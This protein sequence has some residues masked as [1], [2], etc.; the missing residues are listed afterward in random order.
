MDIVRALIG[1]LRYRG[2]RGASGVEYGFIISLLLMGS[3]ASFEMM[4]TRLGE[5][6]QEASVDIGRVDLDHFDV[7]TTTSTTTQAPAGPTADVSFQEKTSEHGSGWKA[8][9]KLTFF[10]DDGDGLDDAD[11]QVTLTTAQ[12]ETKT[13]EYHT[14]NKGKKNLSWSGHEWSA[15][16]TTLTIDWLELDGD[17]FTPNPTTFVLDGYKTD[18]SR[19]RRR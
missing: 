1:R 6:Y 11:F 14:N 4:D 2:D 3:A 17:S 7:T 9:A 19:G 12:G 16:P 5:H 8:K 13:A 15:F 18:G 10:D